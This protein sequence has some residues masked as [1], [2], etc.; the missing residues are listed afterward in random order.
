MLGTAAANLAVTLG[1]MGGIYRRHRAAAG[2]FRP[3]ALPPR[4][5]DKR[6][7]SDNTEGDPTFVITAE[8]AT[9]VGV[10]AIPGRAAAWRPRG[11]FGVGLIRRARN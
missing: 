10:S 9:F 4:F 7:F 11:R 6:C 3:L 2:E 8:R 1:A 5:E